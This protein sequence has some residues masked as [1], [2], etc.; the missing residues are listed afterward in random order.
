MY[1]PLERSQLPC[2]RAIWKREE[3]KGQFS[4]RREEERSDE[5]GLTVLPIDRSQLVR[6]LPRY[7]S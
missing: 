6:N 2:E 3:T 5:M 1:L 7:P 4:A